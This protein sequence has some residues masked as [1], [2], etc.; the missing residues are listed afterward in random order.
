M[1]EGKKSLLSA[2]LSGAPAPVA[3]APAPVVTSS[4]GNLA[5]FPC[6]LH[7]PDDGTPLNI[8]TIA[9]GIDSIDIKK[10]H[11]VGSLPTNTSLPDGRQLVREMSLGLLI[12]GVTTRH[13][14]TLSLRRLITPWIH[15]GD[16]AA[17]SAFH[18][19]TVY[20]LLLGL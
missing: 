15:I 20:L 13:L 14:L 10:V 16:V 8:D 6:L 9:E 5:A 11:V 2:A 17:R 18:P 4:F 7:A 19:P 3:I 12:W 1:K